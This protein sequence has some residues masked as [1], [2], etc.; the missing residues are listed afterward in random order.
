[1]PASN[2]LRAFLTGTS[3]STALLISNITQAQTAPATPVP[4]AAATPAGTVG[5]SQAAPRTEDV[6]VT[7]HNPVE[8]ANGVTGRAPG[9]GLMSVETGAREETTVSR[10]LI[11]KLSPSTSAA[12]IIQY[13]PGTNVATSDPFGFSDQ[14]NVTVRGLNQDE[15]G[16]LYEGLPISDIDSYLPYAS[17]WGDAENYQEVSLAQG[18]V[19]LDAP[20]INSAGGELSVTLRDPPDH[21]GGLIDYS[22]G[23]H[24]TNREFLRV[25]LGTLGAT[26]IRGFISYSNATFGTW[27]GPGQGQ[28]RH[29]DTVLEK[30]WGDGNKIKYV[31]GYN[32]NNQPEY[33]DVTQAQYQ[34]YRNSYNY[35]G[36]LTSPEDT[37]Y[38]QLYEGAW[39]NLN[40]SM[41]SHLAV[42]DRLSLDVTP[43]FYW[44]S[45]GGGGGSVI[46][47]SGNYYG[48]EFVT[49]PLNADRSLVQPDGTLLA[50]SYFI[51]QEF[52]AGVNAHL[53]YKIGSHD[54][55]TVGSWYDYYDDRQEQGYAQPAA[56]GDPPNY[57]GSNFL[58][59]SNGRTLYGEDYHLVSQ[60][61]G[62]YVGDTLSL[63]GDKLE[64]KAGF[65]EVVVGRTGTNN[66]PGPQYDVAANDAQPLPRFSARYN[67][68]STNM[69]FTDASANFRVPAAYSYFSSYSGTG[70]YSQGNTALKDE[71]SIE[72]EVGYRYQAAVDFDVTA[73]NY[74][75]TN[76]NISTIEIENGAQVGRE[77]NVGGQTVRG[78]DAEAGL[79]PFHHIS[80]YVSGEYLYATTDNNFQVSGDYLPTTGKIAVRSPRWQ[81]TGGLSYDDGTFFGNL[82]Y[83]WV[84]SQF[85]DFMNQERIPAH[86]E[87]DATLGIRLPT[88]GFAKHPQIQ[89][90]LYN[91]GGASYLSGVATP[92]TNAR[93]TVGVFGTTIAGTAPTY[94]IA[95]NFAAI[96]TFTSGF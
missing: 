80:P 69:I 24:R 63:L 5:V 78:V 18:T 22:F 91:L 47:E 2:F 14:T 27:R 8:S 23:S 90:N 45:G 30:S 4:D 75:F 19:D 52:H 85:G 35:D 11:A 68:N 9:G 70:F 84:D 31:V 43:Y 60:I 15:I 17:E 25:D 42:S 96:V 58:K 79:R 93:T 21:P 46:N 38:W 51:A 40:M 82:I 44:G 71:F 72:E 6:V 33:T 13:S 32:E 59:F 76:R 50:Q 61:N 16:Y 1:M 81:A 48:T 56:N 12:Q 53:D 73:F 88:I 3:L 74:N 86:N 64:L 57:W 36:T 55:L 49:L 37:N 95:S 89:L 66:L 65:K 41:P 34:Q 26:G 28:R 62:I 39:R 54:T 77:L 67:I 7:G 94:F 20:L 83:R 29:V 92:S 10:D 87:A